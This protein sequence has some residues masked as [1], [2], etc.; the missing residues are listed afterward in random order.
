LKTASQTGFET[1]AHTRKST[2]PTLHR[3]TS[4]Q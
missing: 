2:Y 1:T 4:G 3:L